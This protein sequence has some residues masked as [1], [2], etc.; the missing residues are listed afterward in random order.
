MEY[1]NDELDKQVLFFLKD[2]RGQGR[3]VG[4]WE[5][6]AK[7]Y[8]HEAALVQNDNNASDRQIRNAVE[9]LRRGGALICDMADG[10][11][12]FLAQTLDEYQAFRAKYGGRAF[13]I[14]ETLHEMDKAAAQQWE[15]P[16][17]PRLI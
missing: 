9:R 12:R 4:R 7:I 1:S 10:S 13:Q 17:Q 15:N 16:L 6:V 8:G 2:H 5:L 14:I 3:A 11:G